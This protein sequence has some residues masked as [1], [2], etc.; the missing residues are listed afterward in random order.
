MISFT[1]PEVLLLLLLIPLFIILRWF[2]IL[3]PVSFP[4]V[5]DDWEG[6]QFLW[7]SKT[8]RIFSF[9]EKVLEALSFI[10]A[11]IAFSNPVVHHQEKVFVSRGADILF[12]LDT[13]PSMASRDIADGTRLA[14]AKQAIRTLAQSD[15]GSS[16]GLVA[17]GE[18]AALVVPPTMDR[19]VFFERLDASSIGEMGDGTAI[20]VGLSCAAMHL[21]YSSAPK[22]VI[23]LI[24]DGENNSGS[25]NPLTAARFLKEKGIVL[26]LLGVGT[27][28]RVA[29]EYVDQATGKVYSGTF[30]SNYD[31]LK[32]ASIA[33]SADGR[34]FEVRTLSELTEVLSSIGKNESVVQ[35]YH[36]KNNDEF[37][38]S[39]CI[40]ISLMLFVSAWILKRLVLKEV[41]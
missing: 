33:S 2:K 11:V 18:G 20:G 22:K 21:E 29:L 26:Y 9:L 19:S 36:I 17:M 40:F 27:K 16:L 28:G 7:K 25:V 15:R 39:L 12:V 23:I 4:L 41:L 31:S 3:S 1:N 10:F 32:L 37:F 6:E 13:S 38:Y 35:S 34:F 24:T 8:R 5:L 14:A 30:D